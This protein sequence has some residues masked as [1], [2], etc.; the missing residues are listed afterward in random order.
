[1]N[2]NIKALILMMLFMIAMTV[3]AFAASFNNVNFNGNID[4]PQFIS[5]DY[6]DD[7]IDDDDVDY[8]DD[9]DDDDDDVDDDDDDDDDDDM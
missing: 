3:Q 2:N 8:D 1:M 9:D 4:S 5:L 6:D 7:D